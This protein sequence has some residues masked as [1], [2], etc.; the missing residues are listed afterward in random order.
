MGDWGPGDCFLLETNY[1]NGE[2]LSHLF[3]IVLTPAPH[4]R[5]TIIVNIDSWEPGTKTDNTT[6][7]Q[8]GDHEFIQKKTY[9][10]YR[11]ARIVSVDE[12][13]GWLE[14]GRAKIKPRMDT[15]IL[16]RISDGILK[17]KFTILEVKEMYQDYLHNQ[18]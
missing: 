3:V 1:L 15:S 11:L 17:S 4:T 7:L 5:N 12:I 13:E 6:I 10:N 18:L 8:P 14:T 16:N 9:V 2:V